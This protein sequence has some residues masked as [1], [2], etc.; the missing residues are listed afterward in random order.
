[1][2]QDYDYVMIGVIKKIIQIL[3]NFPE[4]QMIPD[5]KERLDAVMK[6]LIPLFRKFAG[7]LL[8]DSNLINK[9]E[10]DFAEKIRAVILYG[11]SNDQELAL[12][13]VTRLNTYIKE[14]IAII[15]IVKET[16]TTSSPAP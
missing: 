15:E 16:R 7:L 6:E 11:L 13:A 1:M 4:S 12:S 2:D 9:E 14:K 5:F 10:L 8:E 3:Q